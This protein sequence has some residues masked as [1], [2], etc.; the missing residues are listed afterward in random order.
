MDNSIQIINT[1]LHETFGAFNQINDLALVIDPKSFR[2][3]IANL[4]AEKLCGYSQSGLTNL[5]VSDITDSPQKLSR[6]INEFAEGNNSSIFD[7]KVKG[8]D[9]R[10]R[11]VEMSLSPVTYKGEPAILCIGRNIDARKAAEK[12]LRKSEEKYRMLVEGVNVITWL[13]DI[14]NEDY[15]YVSLIAEELLGYPLSK[16]KE[17]DFWFGII[18]PDDR[19]KVISLSDERITKGLDFELDYRVISARAETKW[20]KDLTSVNFIEGKPDTMQGVLIDITDKKVTEEALKRSEEQLFL[21]FE[22]S[23]AGNSLTTVDGKFLRVNKALCKVLGYNKDELLKLTFQELTHPDNITENLGAIKEAIDRGDSSVE[24][25]KRYIKKDGGIVYASTNISFL[26]DESGKVTRYV[27]QVKDITVQRESEEKLR[28]TEL[29]L[30]SLLNNL[31]DIVF[32]ESDR[33]GV[34]VSDNIEEMLGYPAKEF[35]DNESFFESIMYDEDKDKINGQIRSWRVKDNPSPL[36]FEFRVKKKD[37]S[38]IWIEDHMFGINAPG[39]SYWSG[40]MID[41]TNRKNAEIKLEETQMRLSSVLNNLPNVVVYENA[42]GKQFI[43]ENI[44]E[45]LGHPVED[46]Y[47]NPGLFD[48]LIHKGDLKRILDRTDKWYSSGA[49]G[50][51]REIFRI[52]RKDGEYI[53]LED[54]MFKTQRLDGLDYYSGVMIDITER[55]NI[56]TQL[57]RSLKEK[58]LL[59]KEIHHR[60]KNNLQVVSSLLKLQSTSIKDKEARD[61]LLDSQNRVQSMA[62]VHQKLYQSAD[63]ANINLNE[64][65]PQLLH[66]LLHSFKSKGSKINLNMDIEDITIGIDTAIPCGLVINELVSNSL[67]HAF[68]ANGSGSI[69]VKLS[70]GGSDEYTLIIKDSGIG[71]PDSVDFRN[72]ASLGLQ[73]VS[74]LVNQIDGKIEMSEGDGTTFVIKFKE[75]N[76]N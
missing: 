30:S 75:I 18:H 39:R 3:I 64:Y 8:S 16:W 48:S 10:K 12:E 40:F 71:F 61:I 76:S 2:I 72:T 45:M 33:N 49:K 54:H 47:N 1:D 19:R 60:V 26:R 62:L 4:S 23:N 20:F 34:F 37:G 13:Y 7:I 27:A 66:H 15:L 31:S 69:D 68:P 5:P 73:L 43:S 70:A 35:A 29:R 38:Y 36:N 44:I 9:S 14:K 42:R 28:V 51:Y 11:L 53:W 41:V 21:I 6:T 24:V 55:K 17:K 25:E 32:Y 22:N 65:I 59:I 58:E 50:T 52:K 56:E 57:A 74:T 67:K 46:F 63:L